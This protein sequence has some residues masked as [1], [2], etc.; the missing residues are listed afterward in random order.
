MFGVGSEQRTGWPSR[1]RRIAWIVELRSQRV[2]RHG[3]FR[4]APGIP[5]D[6]AYGVDPFRLSELS[7]VGG[8]ACGFADRLPAEQSLRRLSQCA[9]RSGPGRT[10]YTPPTRDRGSHMLNSLNYDY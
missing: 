8:T 9:G 6:V 7:A 2:L 4:I 3:R 1:E 10:G 5:R